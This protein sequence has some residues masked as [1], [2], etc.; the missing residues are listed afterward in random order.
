MLTSEKHVLFRKHQNKKSDYQMH[1]LAWAQKGLIHTTYFDTI[2]SQIV[3][4]LLKYNI[5]G[6]RYLSRTTKECVGSGYPN[7]EIT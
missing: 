6:L 5:C 1:I 7:S 3:D 2:C 4:A